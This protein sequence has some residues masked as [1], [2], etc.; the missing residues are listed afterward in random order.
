MKDSPPDADEKGY[1]NTTL[2]VILIQMFEQNVRRSSSHFLIYTIIIVFGIAVCIIFIDVIIND[3]NC[4][5]VIV[6]L[7]SSL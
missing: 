5:V 3:N 2:P 1:Y 4:T 6:F 7:S